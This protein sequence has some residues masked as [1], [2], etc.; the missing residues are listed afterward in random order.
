MLVLRGR[1]GV[2]ARDP[3]LGKGGMAVDPI[4]VV[5]PSVAGPA[6][7]DPIDDP[8]RLG[9]GG[10]GASTVGLLFG[11]VLGG[12]GGG[13]A[14]LYGSQF[15]FF[16]GTLV[17]RSRKPWALSTPELAILEAL[18]FMSEKDGIS[19]CASGKSR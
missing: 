7:P 17:L 18:A 3:R 10:R 5:R 2:P 12:G 4:L 16:I 1:G 6:E 8:V 9:G 19:I 14:P 11:L 15:V 13:G